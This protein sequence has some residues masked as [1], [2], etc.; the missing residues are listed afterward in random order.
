M[1]MGEIGGK[2]STFEAT[3]VHFSYILFSIAFSRHVLKVDSPDP[4]AVR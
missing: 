1:L 4:S 3:R 2:K